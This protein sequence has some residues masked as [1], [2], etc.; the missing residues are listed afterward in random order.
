MQAASNVLA[1]VRVNEAVV[2][3]HCVYDGMEIE[4]EA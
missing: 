3:S 2:A 4:E 1:W